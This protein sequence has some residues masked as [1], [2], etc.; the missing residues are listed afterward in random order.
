MV[1][2]RSIVLFLILG[3]MPSLYAAN[4]LE[5]SAKEG[6][7]MGKHVVLLAGDE[8]YRSEEAL[9]M[10]AKI[11]SQRHGFKCSVLFSA[12][13]DGTVR[14]DAGDKLTHPEALD[15]ADAIVM[16][17]R[18][19]HWGPE[20]VARFKAAVNRGVPII[21]LRT[22]THAF[23]D[24]ELGNFGK[25]V[26]GEKW[27]S[28]WGVH[29]KQATR[30]VLEP[31]ADV[32][33]IM[34]GVTDIFGTSDVYEAYPP[35]DARILVRGQVL[36]GMLPVDEAAD[37]KKTRATDKVEQ[38]VNE[39]MM[40]VAW[41][42]EV[43]NG[44]GSVNRVMCTT[45]GAAS[46]LPSEGL[47]RLVVNSVYWGLKLDIPQKADVSFVDPYEPTMYGFKASIPNLKV[48]EL[49]LGLS[50]PNR[51][52][53][54]G[55]KLLDLKSGDHIAVVGSGL[56]DRQQHHGWLEA[57]IHAAYPDHDL[58]IRNLGFAADEVNLHPRS[59]EVP[60]TEYF[61]N[62]KKGDLVT[63]V[64]ATEVTYKA[65][66]DFHANVILAYWGFNESFRG[67]T[68]LEEF[69]K[70]LDE[71]L[72]RM[73]ASDFGKGVP[74]VILFSPIAHEDLA[75]ENFPDGAL[76][77]RNLGMYTAA[78][79]QVATDN[80]VPF[81]DLF[82]AS[83][84][85]YK[86]ERKNLTLNG[87]HLTEEGDKALAPIQFQSL[88]GTKAAELSDERVGMIRDAVLEKNVQW[89]HRY[90]TVDQYNIYGQRSRIIYKDAS[91]KTSGF[92]NAKILGEEMAQRDVKT[93]NRDKLIWMVARMDNNLP[94][95]T[96]T[97]ANR[98]Q[99][100]PYMSSEEAMKHLKLPEGAK[101]ELVADE[102]MFPELVNPVQMNFDT[103]GR[104]WV[105][106]WPS[107]PETTPTTKVYDK[108]LVLDLDSKT[109]KATKCTTF[110]DGLNCPTGFQFYKDGVI[111]MQSPDLWFVRDVNGDGKVDAADGKPERL[112]HGLD[113]ADSHHETNSICYEPGGAIYLSDG[114]FHRTNV[115]TLNGPVRNVNG[116]IYRFEPLT[117]KF[118]RYVPYGF[119]NPHGRVF[120][121][122][123]NDIIT[124]ATG[125][126]NYFGPGFSGHLDEGAHPGY[127]QFWNRPSR[128]CPGT[129]IL[130]SRHFPESWQGQ[131]LNANVISFHGI[132]R[133]DMKEDGS[134]LKGETVEPLLE[135]DIQANPN[136][137]PSGVAMA[138]DG[139]LYVMDWSQML[140]GHLQHHLRDPNRDHQHGRIY[141]I[142]FPS[143]PLLKPKKI[144]GQPVNKLVELLSEPENDV[145]L[146]AK[147]EMSKH[148]SEEVVAAVQKWAKQFDAESVA[149]AHHLLEA[150][151]VHQW[152]NKVNLGLLRSL[153]NSPEPRARAQAVRVLCYQR[154][155]IPNALGLLMTAVK[156]VHP[157]VRLEAVRAASFFKGSDVSAAL[158]VAYESL[159]QSTD[160]YLEYCFKETLRQLQF[161]QKNAPLPKD[162]ELLGKLI[163]IS[164]DK[165][166]REL[167]PSEAVLQA[168]LE[169]RSYAPAV[170]EQ[171]LKALAALHKVEPVVEILSSMK[172]FDSAGGK[173][174]GATTELTKLLLASK[175]EVLTGVKSELLKICTDARQ[176]STRRGAWAGY[177]IAEGAADVA[178][179]AAKS[180]TERT[181]LIQAISTIPDPMLRIQFQ[182]KLAEVAPSATGSLLKAVHSALPLMGPANAEANF[183][184]IANS[185]LAGKERESAVTALSNLPR[186][187]WKKEQAGA[188]A[189]SL[190][191]YAKTVSQGDRTKQAFVELTQVGMEMAGLAGNA[192]L[193]KEIRS[194]GVAV[195]VVK[196]VH[197]QMRYD[198]QRLVVE[199]NKPFEIIFENADVMPHNLVIVEPGKHMEIGMAAA[200]MGPNDNKDKQGRT[201]LPKGHSFLDAT[202]L[203]EPGQKETI[204][205][206]PINKEGEYEYVCTFPGHAAI[207]WG[208]LI[209]T[210]DVD[211]YL[212]ANPTASLDSASSV[213]HPIH[214][215]PAQAK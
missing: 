54:L 37:Y 4:Y 124:D 170:R 39:P 27:V 42:R 112:L 46:D 103:K 133:A 95:V 50:L 140:I 158:D 33:A 172:R 196:T 23:N 87:I 69:R 104:L 68:G 164:D 144:Y 29:R 26:L 157:R 160:Y 175:K 61:L 60:T 31:G 198:T 125:N 24:K 9:P 188:V 155:R 35:D 76:N 53:L 178:W 179:N 100:V 156:D 93:A 18:F 186:A 214:P 136:F 210:K 203:L 185:L 111:V 17:L 41:T 118:E 102:T 109:G 83:Q 110:L 180:A 40:P 88:F 8:E 117:S 12:D 187:S 161:V 139:S 119:A 207:M 44:G 211:A 52:Q 202:R 213:T 108:L 15:T 138:P 127:Q 123:G 135:T 73:L 6:P 183:T 209:V 205:V 30:G 36:K 2:L 65:G 145:R 77:N 57:L 191:N 169:R 200:T 66:T 189:E 10:L 63:K 131:F 22:S 206:K 97:P 167:T 129:A 101:I 80:K 89:H 177:V 16:L 47:R 91:G 147:I 75:N 106:A 154:D 201:Y 96:E 166:L 151:W 128:P 121:Y 72:K 51:G 146:W 192:G 197:E 13:E 105:A 168:R 55:V 70:N 141:R 181:S 182:A 1:S 150:L 174:D 162:S 126:A 38:G 81:V 152:H 11:L 132:F 115:E 78:M 120:D 149:D 171:D 67:E 98:E 130:S 90:R 48:D 59:D 7:G 142:T 62:M 3:C 56:A 215:N 199:K 84:Q 71:Y 94:P 193:R 134:G 176:P 21:A 43:P 92:D 173:L 113:A 208:K 99:P 148:D 5:F 82:T 159:R 190:V 20:T 49:G 64:G 143:R 25:D 107:Y 74:K 184:I 212:E 19:R 114:V 194:M 85:L 153:L 116:A 165:A 32:E 137:R 204:K 34:H 58:T 14:A 79:A 28:H 122:W 195:F 163:Q 45:M 86:R